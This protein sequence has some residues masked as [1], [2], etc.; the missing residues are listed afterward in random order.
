MDGVE[1]DFVGEGHDMDEVT[2]CL[3][4]MTNPCGSIQVAGG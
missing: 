4:L 3:D 1:R 2:I